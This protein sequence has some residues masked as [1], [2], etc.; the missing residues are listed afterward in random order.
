[1]LD[2]EFAIHHEKRLLVGPVPHGERVKRVS[3]RSPAARDDQI[4]LHCI[5]RWT[6]A[7][8]ESFG[9]GAQTSRPARISRIS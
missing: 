8:Q 4:I 3:S 9:V 2:D 1:M 5:I 7:D 6:D